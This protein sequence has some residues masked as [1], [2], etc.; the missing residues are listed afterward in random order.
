MNELR[1]A[2]LG[3]SDNTS[4]RVVC[5][6]LSKNGVKLSCLILHKSGF[7]NN[8]S[9]LIRKLKNSGVKSTIK[10]IFSVLHKRS[11]DSTQTT[12]EFSGKIYY[13]TDPNSRE[14]R[15]IIKDEQIDLLLLMVDSIIR[16]SVFSTPNIATLNAHPGWIPKYRGLGGIIYQI[17]D[18][19]L[20]AI[21]VHEVN[22]SIDNGPLVIRKV[23]KFP[24]INT[25]VEFDYNIYISR[26][27]AFIDAIKYYQL[28]NVKYIDT[29]YDPSN[30]T[31]SVT[32]IL[33]IR[34]LQMINSNNKSPDK[35]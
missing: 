18:G 23:F 2:L 24:K 33:R 19:Y 20:P 14:C 6:E 1:I 13:V 28:G 32:P 11:I 35:I 10:R 22:E 31:R 25:E 15:Q 17:N 21:S 3:M 12:K 16:K 5:E 4:T 30:M 27:Q 7:K 29:F 34:A 9:R 26:A 8:W